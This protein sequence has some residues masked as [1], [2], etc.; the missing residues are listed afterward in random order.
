MNVKSQ[1]YGFVSQKINY[2]KNFS[3][4]S[5]IKSTLANLRR[6]IGKHPGSVP[7]I[8]EITLDG[9]PEQ[10]V[11]A[12]MEASDAEWAAHT[13]LT[14]FAL[15]QQ[16]CDIKIKCMNQEGTPFGKAIRKLASNED[17][18]PRVKKRFDSFVTSEN[19]EETAYH[20][21]GL[22][23]LLKSGEIPLDYPALAEDLYKFI[24]YPDNVRLKWGRDF[25]RYQ[26]E[27]KDN[28]V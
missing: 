21:R 25:Y 19:K 23:Q 17:D 27:E 22:V 13:A 1:L 5:K 4:Q 6:G 12:S 28:E 10:Y 8:F 26:K 2:I 3:N 24:K 15:H 14:L 20:L 9:M 7:E 18:L 16:G 11:N